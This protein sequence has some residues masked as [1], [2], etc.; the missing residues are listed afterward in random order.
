VS[1]TQVLPRTAPFSSLHCSLFRFPCVVP[2][3]N[4]ARVRSLDDAQ[5]FFFKSLSADSQKGLAVRDSKSPSSRHLILRCLPP[6][7][8]H[9]GATPNSP[10][11]VAPLLALPTV[12]AELSLLPMLFFSERGRGHGSSLILSALPCGRV[13]SSFF[14]LVSLTINSFTC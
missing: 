10:V 12:S 6:G 7:V 4:R 13:C 2:C 8:L 5:T 14:L 11:F 3:G 9:S 1:R